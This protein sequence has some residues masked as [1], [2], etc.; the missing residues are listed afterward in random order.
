MTHKLGTIA[1]A[2]GLTVGT[3]WAGAPPASAEPECL[4]SSS[5]FD[6]DGTPDVAVGIPGGSGRDGAVRVRLSNAGEPFTTTI[7]GA[8]G[9]GT[10]ITSLSSYVDEGDDALCSQLVVGSPDESTRTDLH[11][12]GVVYVYAWSSATKRFQLRGTFEPQ[13]QGVEGTAQSGARFGAA[14]AAEQRPADQ[15]DPKPSRLFVGAPGFD[16]GDARDTGRVTSFWIDADE[17]P[18]AQD[19]QTFEL[20]E[21]L[22]DEPTPGAALGSSI[23]VAGGLVA[24]GMPGDTVHGKAGAGS[25]LVDYVRPGPDDPGALVLSQDSPGVPGAAER[26]DRFATSVHLV[27][28]P[29]GGRPTLLVGTPGEDVGTTADAGSVTIARI[30][31]S[32]LEPTG[33]VRTVDQN[34][35]GMAGSVE[36][37][38]GFGAAV[39]SMRYGSGTAYLVGVPGEDVGSRRDAGMVQ[40][41]GNGRGWTQRTAGVPGT[42]ETGDR[43]G[44]SLGGAPETG[45][46]KPLVGVPG[47]D[48]GTGAAL[49]GLPVN[50]ASVTYLKGTRA[51]NRFGATV[52]P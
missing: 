5:D 8:P 41:I 17:D 50:G 26:S 19:T 7:T 45:A 6:A 35:S 20:G 38:D 15:V 44:A 21:P 18:S 34:S 24:M 2:V 4:T 25:V 1:A 51:G 10:A 22:T 9:F 16:L 42:A 28:D 40:T 47:E 32:T 23:S 29:A 36:R 49:V 27:P 37:G 13:S 30:S 33:T 3:L 31:R 11:R 12:S 52:A 46:R 48:S 43:M 14:L 39:S